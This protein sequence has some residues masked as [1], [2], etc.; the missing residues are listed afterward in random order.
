MLVVH[1]GDRIFHS[2][3]NHWDAITA[4]RAE[5]AIDRVECAHPPIALGRIPY[6]QRSRPLALGQQ[7]V[8]HNAGARV[9]RLYDTVLQRG[10]D[11]FGLDH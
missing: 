1:A 6:E 9:T 4:I 5:L 10:P 2:R 3:L 11:A 7:I 8:D